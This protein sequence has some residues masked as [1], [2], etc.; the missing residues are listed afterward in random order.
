YPQADVTPERQAVL[1]RLSGGQVLPSLSSSSTSSLPR[2]GGA[3][4]VGDGGLG[5]NGSGGAFGNGV[6]RAPGDPPA[7]PNFVGGT[8]SGRRG[9]RG[10]QRREASVG[11]ANYK[12]VGSALLVAEMSVAFLQ[13]AAHFPAIV[14]DVLTR[15]GELLRVFNSR[16][17]Q[18]VLGAGAIHSTAKLKSI[19]AKHLALCCQSID[20]VRSLMPY[21]KAA[22]A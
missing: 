6:L 18:L 1:D 8:R 11:G 13:F 2:S 15:L 16:S 12:T 22:L 5:G 10:Q 9:G 21:L 19:S 17:T 20:L 7:Q 14:T 3:A 4:G